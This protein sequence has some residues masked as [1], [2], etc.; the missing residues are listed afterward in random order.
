M[1]TFTIDIH[2]ALVAVFGAFDNF[3]VVQLGQVFV[4]EHLSVVVG[5]LFGE[6]LAG[7]HADETA[8]WNVIQAANSPATLVRAESL[9]SQLKRSLS[10]AI[11]AGF[12][13]RALGV[14]LVETRDDRLIQTPVLVTGVV[15]HFTRRST[16]SSLCI[17]EAYVIYTS[18]VKRTKKKISIR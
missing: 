18:R 13:A 1:I 4:A 16:T 3:N 10:H 9:Q 15:V 7:V 6:Q 11:Q 2:V 17:L 5:A 12:T 8:L 14:A